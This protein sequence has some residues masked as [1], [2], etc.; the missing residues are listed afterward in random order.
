MLS[1]YIIYVLQLHICA[2]ICMYVTKYLNSTSMIINVLRQ[3]HGNDNVLLH[4]TREIFRGGKLLLVF[5]IVHSTP[6]ELLT[7]LYIYDLVDQLYEYTRVFP[8]MTN[9]LSYQESLCL[10]ESKDLLYMVYMFS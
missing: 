7:P 3:L 5:M 1:T 6:K 10:L 4:C 8:Q 9:S 2:Y